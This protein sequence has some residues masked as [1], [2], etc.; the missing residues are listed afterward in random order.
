[1]GHGSNKTPTVFFCFLLVFVSRRK[2]NDTHVNILFWGIRKVMVEVEVGGIFV[3]GWGKWKLLIY[4]VHI[5]DV[6]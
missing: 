4:D 5:V 3:F 6:W 1:M 2:W